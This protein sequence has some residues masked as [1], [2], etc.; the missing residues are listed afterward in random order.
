M[1]KESEKLHHVIIH[2]L[3]SMQSLQKTKK[4]R[5]LFGVNCQLSGGFF[6]TQTA[7]LI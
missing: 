2:G 6:F 3:I 4:W 5:R 7:K 1:T